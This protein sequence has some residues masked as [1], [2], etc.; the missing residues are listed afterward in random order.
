VSLAKRPSYSVLNSGKLRSTL[1][2]NNALSMPEQIE[3]QDWRQQLNCMLRR[4]S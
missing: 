4:L 1:A 2:T 3:W